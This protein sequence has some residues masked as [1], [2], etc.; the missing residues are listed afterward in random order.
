LTKKSATGQRGKSW[1]FRHFKRTINEEATMH[2]NGH[3]DD[4][5]DAL[6]L[7]PEQSEML[8]LAE[9]DFENGEK[10]IT[11]EQVL[12]NARAKVRAWTHSPSQSA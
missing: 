8:R 10:G 3:D 5:Q 12:E 6:T 1:T 4:E 11:A 2:H 9:V 7:T